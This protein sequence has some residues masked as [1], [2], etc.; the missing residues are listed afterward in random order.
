[1][2]LKIVLALISGLSLAFAISL[3]FVFSYGCFAASFAFCQPLS[4]YATPRP[5]RLSVALG[6]AAGVG[7]WEWLVGS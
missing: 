6:H 4:G 3:F 5:F 7:V 1:M 2:P